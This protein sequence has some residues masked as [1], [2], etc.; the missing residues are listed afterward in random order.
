VKTGTGGAGFSSFRGGRR[1]FGSRGL[2]QVSPQPENRIPSLYHVRYTVPA[3]NS[4]LEFWIDLTVLVRFNE[5]ITIREGIVKTRVG[6]FSLVALFCFALGCQD[7]AVRT[8]LEAM[9]VR[10]AIEEQNMGLV[11]RML[12]RLDTG[13]F[14]AYREFFSPEYAYYLPSGI[15]TPANLDEMI[16]GVKVYFN[17]FPDLV[18]HVD[19]LLA[20]KDKVILRFTARG[21]HRGELDGLPPTGNTME[22]SSIE[23]FTIKNGKIVEERQEAD[24]L[25]M[26]SHLGLELGP[27]AH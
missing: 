1:V 9:K 22:V 25:G 16:A 17:A 14:E 26:M 13:D 12:E 5:D 3:A 4:Q 8:E 18:H 23:I 11:R 24:M 27:K 7:K 10:A 2:G 15:A 19:E 21:T 6:V 20:F